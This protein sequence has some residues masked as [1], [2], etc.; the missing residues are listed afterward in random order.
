MTIVSVLARFVVEGEAALMLAQ[1]TV[2]LA[3]MYKYAHTG[4][5][6]ILGVAALN[7]SMIYAVLSGAARQ[8][9]FS[10]LRCTD[11]GSTLHGCAAVLPLQRLQ[12]PVP[13]CKR[14]E[15]TLTSNIF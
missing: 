14:L 7:S 13:D 11:T 12:L 3:L 10:C 4:W 2:L 8:V 1:N 15:I 9:C 5:P 6:R